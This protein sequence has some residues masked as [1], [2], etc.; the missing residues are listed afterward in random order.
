MD[1]SYAS[2]NELVTGLILFDIDGVIFDPEKFGKLI[3]TK[4]VKILG[5]SEEELISANADYYSKLSERTDFDP[6]G[7][8]AYLSDRFGKDVAP[9][10]RVFWEDT[11][12][13]KNSLYPEAREVLEKLKGEKILGIFSQGN[14]DLQN[15]K[16]DAAELRDYFSPEYIFIHKRK[17]SD[18]AIELLPREATFIDNKHDVVEVLQKFVDV[19]W[20]NRKSDESDPKIKT[21]HSLA[22][23][24]D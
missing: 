9:L 17:L 14:R 3:R 13:Y 4:F 12:I 6:R 10:D 5:I 1:S 21:I 8:T 2:R 7:I 18:E 19:I 15:R 22:E 23:L 16:L 11:D 24:T 20:I